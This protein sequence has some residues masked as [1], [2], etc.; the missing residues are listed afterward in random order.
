MPLDFFAGRETFPYL[1]SAISFPAPS[2]QLLKSPCLVIFKV[3]LHYP[4]D[5]SN[6]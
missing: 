4:T 1:F 3:V 6:S 2:E 5:C